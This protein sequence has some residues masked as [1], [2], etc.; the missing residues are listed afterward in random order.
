MRIFL[1]RHGFNDFDDGQNSQGRRQA[2]AAGLYLVSRSLAFDDLKGF[3]SPQERAKITAQIIGEKIGFS[4]WVV[5]PWLDV[6]ENPY[7]KIQQL[8][9]GDTAIL[10][11]HGPVIERINSRLTGSCG[12]VKNSSIHEM[13]PNAKT[14]KLVFEP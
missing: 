10:V 8:P 6:E 14:I 7:N 12:K 1:V 11:T 13:D 9:P 3:S 4:S 5:V 2:E